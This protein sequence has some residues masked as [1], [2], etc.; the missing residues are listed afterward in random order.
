MDEEKKDLLEK[1]K[2]H[3]HFEEGMDDSMLSFYLDMAKDYVKT[4]T[5][6]QQEYLILMIAGI[7]YEYRVA[8]GELEAALNAVTPFIIQGVIQH[9]EK[10]DE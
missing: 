1:F 5:G 10:T 6:G 3:I 2:S 7:G 8:E 4:A 9:A